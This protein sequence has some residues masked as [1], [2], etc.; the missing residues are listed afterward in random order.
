MCIAYECS[1]V[2]ALLQLCLRRDLSER[3]GMCVLYVSFH[4]R[5]MCVL[6]VSFLT[7]GH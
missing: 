3:R 4:M 6:Y 2:A 1:S 7:L 5:G